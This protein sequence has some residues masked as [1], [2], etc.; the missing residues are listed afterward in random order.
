MDIQVKYKLQIWSFLCLQYT[1]A[2]KKTVTVVY[3]RWR[4]LCGHAWADARVCASCSYC[5]W[6]DVNEE[7][8]RRD[9]SRVWAGKE[10]EAD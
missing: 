6:Q 1:S 9:E 10:K 2:F 7:V 8:L 3:Q 5:S 4:V